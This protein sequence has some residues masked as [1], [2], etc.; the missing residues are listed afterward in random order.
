MFSLCQESLKL[1]LVDEPLPEVVLSQKSCLCA[2][3]GIRKH[4][5][6]RFG[7]FIILHPIREVSLFF[8]LTNNKNSTYKVNVCS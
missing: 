5:E 7:T 8:L 1:I 6:N 3:R 2:M 4:I